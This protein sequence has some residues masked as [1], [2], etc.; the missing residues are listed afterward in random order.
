[1]SRSRG[2]GKNPLAGQEL[3]MCISPKPTTRRRPLHWLWRGARTV[4]VA[5]IGVI[6]VL[7]ALEKYLL[8]RPTS[9]GEHWLAPPN[10]RVED[11]EL[12][13]A[14]GTRIHTW[15]C[16]V[17]GADGAMLYCHG[18]AG[19][20]SH[21]SSQIALWQ[22]ELKESVLIFD[23]P[24]YGKSEGKPSESGCY[25]AAEAAYG[26]LV[27]RA[28]VPAERITLYGGS[29]GGGV[30][31]EL[32]HRGH[33]HRAL[34]LLKTFTSVPDMA[35][36]EFPWLPARWLVRSRFD[37]LAK[38]AQCT[39]AVFIAHGDCDRLIPHSHGERLYAVAREPKFFLTLHDS[40]HNDAVGPVFFDALRQFL[41]KIDIQVQ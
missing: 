1:M 35:Q 39:R 17:S 22:A 4:A 26:W 34:V 28:K 7:M 10:A 31:V 5:Y 41:L 27:D 11:I 3:P 30:A 14:D 36:K 6:L 23:Y 38:I 20:L 13:T 15:W 29:L 40:D 33:A 8:F 9:A 19:N 24:G 21:R 32:A 16:P 2:A 12:Q 25:A 37:N 18:N